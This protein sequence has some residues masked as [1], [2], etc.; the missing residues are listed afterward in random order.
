[1][2][3]L[4]PKNSGGQAKPLDGRLTGSIVDEAESVPIRQAHVWIHEWTGSGSYESKPDT[5]GH[6]DIRLPYG[7]YFVLVGAPGFAAISKYVWIQPSK[8]I[9]LKLRML[10]DSENME[11]SK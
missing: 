4:A 6:F 1:M 7:R 3:L 2:V 9:I 5:V 8:P 10:P 11:N